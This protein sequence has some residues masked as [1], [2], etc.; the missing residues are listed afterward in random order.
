[1]KMYV[2]L[3]Y[4]ASCWAGEK[5]VSIQTTIN[6]ADNSQAQQTIPLKGALVKNNSQEERL[7]SI[8]EDDD[9]DA[10]TC[11]CFIKLRKRLS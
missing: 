7:R 1:M 6:V 2:L 4:C 10:V 5:H 9:R 8:K 3:F 11:C